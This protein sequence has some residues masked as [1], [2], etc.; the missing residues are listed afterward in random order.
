ML[1]R[2]PL[3][4]IPRRNRLGSRLLTICQPREGLPRL[5]R[6][7]RLIVAGRPCS[8]RWSFYRGAL[9]HH[10]GIERR[11]SHAIRTAW[12]EDSNGAS[13]SSYAS[14]RRWGNGCSVRVRSGPSCAGRGDA[15]IL[16]IDRLPLH[17]W[18]DTTE[19]QTDPRPR[20]DDDHGRLRRDR[21]WNN[22]EPGNRRGRLRRPES[23][24]LRR[25][26]RTQLRRAKRTQR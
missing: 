21:P 14:S 23:T 22:P 2:T 24:Q 15:V 5:E 13:S 19:S 25:T 1:T 17:H 12:T 7:P 18:V 9:H 11:S 8:R 4:R 26:K 20:H 10:T 6:G 16:F 3:G